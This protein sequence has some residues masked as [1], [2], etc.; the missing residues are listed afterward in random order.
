[1]ISPPLNKPE[2]TVLFALGFVGPHD[3]SWVHDLDDDLLRSLHDLTH[4]QEDNSGTNTMFKDMA[5][6]IMILIS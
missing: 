1:L 5:E 2:L 3:A 4:Y 6:A